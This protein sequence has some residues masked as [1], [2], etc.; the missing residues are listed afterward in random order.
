[1]L[2]SK[3]NDTKSLEK[4]EKYLGLDYNIDR[5]VQLIDFSFVAD[6]YV[7]ECF[8]ADYRQM[9]RCR[10]GTRNHE[11]EFEEYC[12]YAMLIVERAI[13]YYFSFFDFNIVKSE[14]QEIEKDKPKIL[15]V[16]GNAKAL[17]D[18][19]LAIKLYCF[20]EEEKLWSINKLFTS[21]RKVRNH[22]SHG[23]LDCEDK[24]LWFSETQGR[25][26]RNGYPIRYDGLVDFQ[27][28]QKDSIRWNLFNNTIK[29]SAEY[30]KYIQ[31]SWELKQPFDEIN[32]K[33]RELI[34]HIA[35][36]LS[37]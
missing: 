24:L 28:L 12:R 21:V 37:K 4:I 27:E 10:F 32:I 1:M 29:E 18:I 11:P 3:R 23:H 13:N 36:L 5:F 30:Q 20:C 26:I 15:E 22:Q 9:L 33:L 14:M 25:Y 17:Q 16:I 19:S 2:P 34:E 35:T 31:L 8:K 6:E 7:K